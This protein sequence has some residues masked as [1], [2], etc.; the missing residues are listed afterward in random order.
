[1]ELENRQIEILSAKR[2]LRVFT[3]ILNKGVN[4]RSSLGAIKANLEI[5]RLFNGFM[6][7]LETQGR[8]YIEMRHHL[9]RCLARQV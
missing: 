5:N 7:K 4:L 9:V 1:M 6:K 3:I 2:L 8:A